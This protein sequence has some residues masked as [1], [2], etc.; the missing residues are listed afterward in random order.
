MRFLLIGCE[1]LLRELCDAITRSAHTI[2]IEFL[3]KG[4]H[5]LGGKRMCARLQQ[6]VDRAD[7]AGHDAVLLGYALCGNGLAGLEARQV[8]LVVPRAHDCIALLMGSRQ[9][10]QEYFNANPGVYYRST[11]WFERGQ[12]LEQA[13]MHETGVGTSLGDLIEKYGEDNGRYLFE[14]LHNYRN[15]YRKLTY[16]ETG[17]ETGA[18]FEDG[19]RVEAAERGW[20]FEKIQGDLTLFRRLA[21]GD[22]DASDFLVVEPGWR[23]APSYDETVIRSERIPS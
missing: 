3:P 6:A 17:L 12:S 7:P 22:W 15:N 21:A 23:I 1:V 16:I 20:N 18:H 9:R 4:L 8:R 10:Y 11:G 5:D 2:D 19:S 13:A 14:E